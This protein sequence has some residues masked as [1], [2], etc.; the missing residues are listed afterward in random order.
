ML[1][2]QLAKHAA[3]LSRQIQAARKAVLSDGADS[4]GAIRSRQKALGA[5]RN[6][7]SALGYDLVRRSE[8]FNTSRSHRLGFEAEIAEIRDRQEAG[9]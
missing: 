7:A 1:H 6:M 8:T 4:Y 2:D 5:L 9:L 3:I